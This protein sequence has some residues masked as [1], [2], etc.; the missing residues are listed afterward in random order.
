MWMRIVLE[1]KKN[2]YQLVALVF[3]S[4]LIVWF[5]YTELSIVGIT[6]MQ[7]V[8][9]T[10]YFPSVVIVTVLLGGV[11]SAP[12]WGLAVAICFQNILLWFFLKKWRQR[13]QKKT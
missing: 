8:I 7:E 10:F 4:L 12:A 13:G 9:L 2:I 1:A 3:L 5:M 6:L 11:H